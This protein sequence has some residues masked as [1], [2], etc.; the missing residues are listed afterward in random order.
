MTPTENPALSFKPAGERSDDW[1]TP[2]HALQ[3]LLEH[4]N[5]DW[6]IW[7]CCAGK[8]NIVRALRDLGL[9]VYASDVKNRRDFLKMPRG[10]LLEEMEF[11]VRSYDCIVTNPPYS[12]KQQFLDRAYRLGKPFAFLMPLFTLEGPNRQ[13]LFEKYGLELILLDHRIDFE[14]PRGQN[15]ANFAVAWFTWGL[16]IG[17]QL[18][19]GKVDRKKP[20]EL[21]AQRA[22]AGK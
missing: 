12:L 14:P 16:K 3:P 17:R 4:I 18:T 11:V 5:P 13:S 6:L 7:E 21:A 19:F 15:P 9:L 2:P 8:G 10:Q 22:V 20:L 1:Q